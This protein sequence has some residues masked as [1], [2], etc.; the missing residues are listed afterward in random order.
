MYPRAWIPRLEKMVNLNHISENRK[1]MEAIDQTL[2]SETLFAQLKAERQATKSV[3]VQLGNLDLQIAERN[4]Q[5]ERS[6][7]I[8]PTKYQELLTSQQQ[9]EDE[10]LKHNQ[11]W[12]ALKNNH[13]NHKRELT[14]QIQSWQSKYQKSLAEQAIKDAFI[15]AGGD[16]TPGGGGE[17]LIEYFRDRV[18]IGEDDRLTLLDR[19]GH[20]EVITIEEKMI[21][22][23][24]GSLSHLFQSDR[25]SPPPQNPRS[26]TNQPIIYTKEQARTGK[27]NLE[28]VRTGKAIIR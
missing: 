26:T 23:K 6:R 2:D 11:D 9:R 16:K 3:K 25:K 8:D 13:E 21:E 28:W 24:N 10:E 15:A 20:P 14:S 7:G 1:Y 19:D 4:R 18:Q 12:D 17:L 22:I 27:A 5:L